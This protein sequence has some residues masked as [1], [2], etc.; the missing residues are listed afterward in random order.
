MS[1]RGS[2]YCTDG[3]H[4][5]KCTEHKL[6]IHVYTDIHES[7]DVVCVE[8]SCSTCYCEYKFLM[9]KHLGEQLAKQLKAGDNN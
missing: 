8:F 4:N 5:P 2:L 3:P 1:T 7:D 9:A 6:H